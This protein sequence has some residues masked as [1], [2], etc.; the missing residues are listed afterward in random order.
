[1]ID[2]GVV[3]EVGAVVEGK[4]IGEGS[5]IEVNAKVGKGV[6]LGKVCRQSCER[7]VVLTLRNSI[8]RSGL[9][10]KFQMGTWSQIS[11]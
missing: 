1:M 11:R 7:G 10:V 4:R 8:A 5:V 9:I 2:N 6:V 3:V